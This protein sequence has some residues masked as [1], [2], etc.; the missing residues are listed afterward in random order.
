[1]LGAGR[2]GFRPDQYRAAMQDYRVRFAATQA[3]HAAERF[4]K[5]WQQSQSAGEEWRQDVEA[6]TQA[7]FGFPLSKL[8]EL[9][10]TPTRAAQFNVV[11]TVIWGNSSFSGKSSCAGA[12]QQYCGKEICSDRILMEVPVISARKCH[13]LLMIVGY[14]IFGNEEVGGEVRKARSENR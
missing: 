10:P 11:K 8:V 5:Q 7:E 14:L 2:L 3:T 4:R 9:L 12:G 6:A 13:L 1:M